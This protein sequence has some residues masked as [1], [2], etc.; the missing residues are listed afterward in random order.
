MEGGYTLYNGEQI[1][2]YE[3]AMKYIKDDTSTVIFAGEEYGTG[4]SR[5]WAAKRHAIAGR[6]CSGGQKLRPHPP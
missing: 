1:L 2:I 3:A 4:S 5:D 6:E